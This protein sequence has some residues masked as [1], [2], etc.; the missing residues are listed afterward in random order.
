[1]KEEKSEK[2]RKKQKKMIKEEMILKI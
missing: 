1:M 2:I